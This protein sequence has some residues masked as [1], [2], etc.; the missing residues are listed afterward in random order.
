MFILALLQEGALNGFGIVIA[1]ILRFIGTGVL[2]SGIVIS[3]SLRLFARGDKRRLAVS[4]T[5]MYWADAG[6]VTL[7][8]SVVLGNM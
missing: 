7:V 3:G 6:L 1:D 4:R 2:I 8:V 5:A